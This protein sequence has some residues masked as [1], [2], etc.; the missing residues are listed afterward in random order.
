[1]QQIG[2]FELQV[3]CIIG[4]NDSERNEKQMIIMDLSI[5]TEEYIDYVECAS[6][7]TRIAE[8]G[9]F[10]LMET[11]GHEIIKALLLKWPMAGK[12]ALTLKKPLALP[13]AVYAFVRVEK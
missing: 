9:H 11:L 10:L 7:C 8:E 13:N 1:M 5:N 3:H 4:L 12:I 2:F 6:I